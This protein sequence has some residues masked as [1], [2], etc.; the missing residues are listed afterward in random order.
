M[1]QLIERNVSKSTIERHADAVKRFI[2]H[3]G[4]VAVHQ[5]TEDVIEQFLEYLWEV[6]PSRQRFYDLSSAFRRIVATANRA[7]ARNG[8]PLF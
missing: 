5:I 6:V 8:T 2:E 7:E 4:N 1:P 3:A